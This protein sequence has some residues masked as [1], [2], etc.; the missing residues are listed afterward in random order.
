MIIEINLLPWREQRRERRGRLFYKVLGLAA[1]LGLGGGYGV[2]WHYQQEVETQSQRN[3]LIEARGRRL[4]SA[5]R[6]VRGLEQTRERMLEQVR[7]LTRLQDG[8]A[9]TVHVMNDLAV[10][11]V[12]GVYYTH[13]NR[14]GNDLDLSGVA[15]N[16]RQV[17]DQLRA[18]ASVAA[19]DAPMLSE[20]EVEVEEGGER[21]R[22]RLRMRQRVPGAEAGVSGAVSVGGAE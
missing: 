16:N 4:D 10:S 15:E 17:T 3:A 9:Q 1:L 21:R 11:L 14:Q 5:I 13:L 2:A 12:D 19:F 7:V 18:L 22:F 6:E 20:V 8:R